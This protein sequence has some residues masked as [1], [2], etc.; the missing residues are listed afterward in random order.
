MG[1]EIDLKDGKYQIP[2]KGR[3]SKEEEKN[4]YYINDNKEKITKE[5]LNTNNNEIN[6]DKIEEDKDKKI[7]PTVTVKIKIEGGFWEKEFN[8]ET[9]LNQISSEFKESNNLEKIKKNH[10]IEFIYNNSSLQMDSRLLNEI[11]DE[12]QTEIILNQEMKQIPGIEKKEII[13]PVD[14]IG[15]PLDNPFEIYTLNIKQKKISKIKYS[16]EKERIFELNKFGINSAYCNGINHLFISGGSD[17]FTDEILSIFWVVDLK[18]KLFQVRTNMP[19]PKKNHRM[20]Y[21][22]KKVYM[23]GGN[24]E[25]TLFYDISR[26]N[27]TEWAKLKKKKFEPSLIKFNE[28]LFCIDASGKYSKD[29]NFEKINL[30]EDNPEWETVNPKISPDLLNLNFSQRFF[31]LIEDKNENI[32]FVGGIYDNYLGNNLSDKHYFNLQYNEEENIIEKSNMNLRIEGYEEIN[33]SEKAFLPI[34]E[35]TYVIFP[36]FKRRAPKVLYFY[37]DRNAL[38]INSYRS[39]QRLTQI[40]NQ[41]RI[42]SLGESMNGLN[43]NMPVVKNKNIYIN[44]DFRTK[45]G[46]NEVNLK[47]SGIVPNYE[48]NLKINLNNKNNNNIYEQNKFNNYFKSEK[49]YIQPIK[50]NM[51]EI[52]KESSFEILGA[53]KNNSLIKK[54]NNNFSTIKEEN[55]IVNEKQNIPEVIDNVTIEKKSSVENKEENKNNNIN[56]IEKTSDKET[57]SLREDEISKKIEDNKDNNT[58]RKIDDNN[59]NNNIKEEPKNETKI[60]PEEREKELNNNIE[61]IKNEKS[62][63]T[64]EIF[65]YDKAYSLVTFHSSVNTAHNYAK[66][67][68]NKEV[69]NKLKMKYLIPPKEVNPKTL[70]YV[71]RKFDN[72]EINGFSDNYNY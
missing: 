45:L 32:I 14:F 63:T 11:L 21:I 1:Q 65:D 18:D 25:S 17:S 7:I 39:N 13:E 53:N 43:L 29:Y 50:I 42:V 30:I 19:L 40:A 46:K 33:L 5:N 54:E 52:K 56:N 49:N 71:R 28:Y 3:S 41:T 57:K 4:S 34:N 62:V 22:E 70:K 15:K 47:K 26:N 27:F 20:I 37:K 69:K 12:D 61:N 44:E 55:I 51:N 8:K 66:L 24:D 31:G 72:Y 2:Y 58:G 48:N 23:I 9:P 68:N 64:M 6:I 16:K 67:E 60:E 59:I 38:E 10:Y 36:D 35:N